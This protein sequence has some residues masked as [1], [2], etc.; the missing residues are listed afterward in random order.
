MVYNANGT[1][2]PEGSHFQVRNETCRV[3]KERKCEPEYGI[4]LSRILHHH[5]LFFSH[6]SANYRIFMSNLKIPAIGINILFPK[7]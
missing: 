4:G 3:S 1:I 5:R 7:L 2:P 6:R